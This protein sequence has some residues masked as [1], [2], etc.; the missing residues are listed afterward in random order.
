[1]KKNFK[2]KKGFFRVNPLSDKQMIKEGLRNPSLVIE[3][4]VFAKNREEKELLK[5]MKKSCKG[6]ISPKLAQKLKHRL[7][8]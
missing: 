8:S 5:R 6:S 4:E 1:M 2:N 3:R 7:L